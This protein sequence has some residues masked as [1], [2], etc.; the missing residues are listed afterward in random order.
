[1]HPLSCLHGSSDN[2]LQG[3]G[4]DEVNKDASSVCA[5]YCLHCKL[6]A[7]EKLS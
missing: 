7:G 2:P 5:Q 1:M 6:S 4:A 3:G